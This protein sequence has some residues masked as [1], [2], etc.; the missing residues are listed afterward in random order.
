MNNLL[1]RIVQ[2]TLVTLLVAIAYVSPADA[3]GDPGF[4]IELEAG[5]VWQSRNDVQIPNDETGTRFSLQDLAGNGPWFAGRLYATWNLRPRHGLRLLLAPLS[6][7]ET[8]TLDEPVDFVGETYQAGVP[9][10]ATYQFNSWR[11]SY[12]YRFRDGERWRWWVG[13][14]AK[15]RDAKVELRQGETTSKDTDVGFVPLLHLAADWKL[16]ERWH[17][18]FDFDGLA[19]GPGRAIDLAL[20]LGYDLSDSW[21]MTAGYR[22]V[23][24]GADTDEVYN[25]AWFNAFVVSGVYRF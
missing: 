13:F 4:A 11:L 10:E 9:T 23:E 21:R 2:L 20:K 8:G 25:F 16:A 1:S 19:G 22:T 6:I 3:Q 5:P 12:R 24:G 14:T 17:F 15:I 7:T 18:L